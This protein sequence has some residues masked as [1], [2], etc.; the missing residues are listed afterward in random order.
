MLEAAAASEKRAAVFTREADGAQGAR[1]TCVWAARNAPEA[2][3][4]LERRT[5]SAVKTRRGQ[6]F[7]LENRAAGAGQKFE[8]TG[9]CAVRRHGGTEIANQTN[10]SGSGH[11][12]EDDSAAS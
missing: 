3:E 1:E 7:G 6:P 9:D 11:A 10:A 2:V 5:V 12:P 4:G 8:A